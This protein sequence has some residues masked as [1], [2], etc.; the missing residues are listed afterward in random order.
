M[1]H[2]SGFIELPWRIVHQAHTLLNCC[3]QFML[4]RW[5]SGEHRF[6]EIMAKPALII[7]ESALFRVGQQP[8]LNIVPKKNGDDEDGNYWLKLFCRLQSVWDAA[9]EVARADDGAGHWHAENYTEANH[10]CTVS[11]AG[12]ILELLLNFVSLS[13]LRAACGP[14]LRTYS[15]WPSKAEKIWI[16]H[17]VM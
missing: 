12:K 6:V 11:A 1:L 14:A 13:N 16:F 15:P 4:R 9:S 2:K 7:S 3:G 10:I 17:S 8:I 5:F